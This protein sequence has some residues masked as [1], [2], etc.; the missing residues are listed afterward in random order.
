MI[1]AAEA[2]SNQFGD[3]EEVHIVVIPADCVVSEFIIVFTLYN[4]PTSPC[5]DSN[6]ICTMLNFL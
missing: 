3:A 4:Q 6:C 1:Q 2:T 5:S